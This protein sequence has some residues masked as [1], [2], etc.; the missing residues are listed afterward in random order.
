M[1][2]C[3]GIGWFPSHGS[4]RNVLLRS[5]FIE[6]GRVVKAVLELCRQNQVYRAPGEDGYVALWCLSVGVAVGSLC[7]LG[8]L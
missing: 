8:D 1:S 3:R 5:L 2:R 7:V 6:L 4:L